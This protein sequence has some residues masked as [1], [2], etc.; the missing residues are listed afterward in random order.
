[1]VKTVNQ[2][3]YC[4]DNCGRI[5]GSVD[6]KTFKKYARKIINKKPLSQIG[7]N[8]KLFCND[9]CEIEYKNNYKKRGEINL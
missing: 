8:Y 7:K 6:F 3:V 5:L 1:M 9:Y 4:C 2:E